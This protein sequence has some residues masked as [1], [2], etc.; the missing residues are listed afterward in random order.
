V[1]YEIDVG[2]HQFEPHS[3]K[4]LLT[5]TSVFLSEIPHQG[6]TKDSTSILHAAKIDFELIFEI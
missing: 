6:Q 3:H 1:I 2:F 5:R 4:L